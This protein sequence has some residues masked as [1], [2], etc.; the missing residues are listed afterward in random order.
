[1]RKVFGLFTAGV[2]LIYLINIIRIADAMDGEPVFNVK[3][4]TKYFKR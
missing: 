3:T 4:I 1:M 2:L